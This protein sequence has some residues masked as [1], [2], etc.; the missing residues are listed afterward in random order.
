METKQSPPYTLTASGISD[1]GLVR[2]NNEDIWAELPDDCFFILADG[3]GGHQAGEKAA[4]ETVTTMCHLVREK[5]TPILA[6]SSI[7]EIQKLLSR[8]IC[9][10]NNYIF[11]MGRQ[12]R[13]LKG[14]GTTLCCV[15]FHEAGLIY[16]HVGDSR[17][18]RFRDDKLVQLTKD[19]SLLCQL[20]DQGQL[21][22]KSAQNFTHKHIITKAIGTEPRVEPTVE[23]ASLEEG[24]LYLLCSDGLT[25]L[26]THDEIEATI[27]YALLPSDAALKLVEAAN[28][29]GGNDN[30]TVVMV[31]VENVNSSSYE[32]TTAYETA[33]NR[34][35]ADLSR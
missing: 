13:E 7:E 24:D 35:L 19:H 33:T 30:I 10:V 31:K 2:E 12:D 32:T 1:I 28:I 26:I 11:Q 17:I 9:Y 15:L 5:I 23:S 3:M 34:E 4:R 22:E 18:Y 29:K 25:D 8:A 16:A 20:L 14:M 6:T 21:D 27:K